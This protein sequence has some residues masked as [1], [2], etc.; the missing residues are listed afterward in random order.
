VKIRSAVEQILSFNRTFPH[1]Q[2]DG[3]LEKVTFNTPRF[4][5]G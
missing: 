5:W 2:L 4:F 1:E 3:K